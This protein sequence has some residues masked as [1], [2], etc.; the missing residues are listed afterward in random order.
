M[1]HT[2]LT[3]GHKHMPLTRA[4]T[5]EVGHVVAD[6]VRCIRW[7]GAVHVND[8]LTAPNDL[9][10]DHSVRI[11]RRREARVLEQIA[12]DKSRNDTSHAPVTATGWVKGSNRSVTKGHRG[13][14]A[15]IKC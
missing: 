11:V 1:H 15:R 14:K 10:L 6:S 12:N 13:G 3:L 4:L 8:L 9:A 5:R 7:R 2:K